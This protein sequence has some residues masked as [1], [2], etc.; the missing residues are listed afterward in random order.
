MKTLLKKDTCPVEV[1]LTGSCLKITIQGLVPGKKNCKMR[2]RHGLITNPKYQKIIERVTND[3]LLALK[4]FIQT[5]GGGTIPTS[6]KLSLI[7]SLLPGDD[8]WELLGET[9]T[10]GWKAQDATGRIEIKL[11]YMD[12]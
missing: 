11:Q 4:S 2:T 7:S 6:E 3:L 1:E 10:R 5:G 12:E 9:R 8:C